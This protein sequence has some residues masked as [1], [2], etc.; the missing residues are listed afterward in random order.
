MQIPIPQIF[1]SPRKSKY[2]KRHHLIDIRRVREHGCRS[3]LLRC[4]GHQGE[5]AGG[6]VHI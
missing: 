3:Q 2:Y 5:P 1:L 6:K 4:G